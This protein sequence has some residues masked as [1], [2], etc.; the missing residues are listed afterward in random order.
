MSQRAAVKELVL[1]RANGRC[2]RCRQGLGSGHH[3][4]YQGYPVLHPDNLT[5]LCTPCHLDRLSERRRK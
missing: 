5:V 1:L 2:E 4:H 3:F